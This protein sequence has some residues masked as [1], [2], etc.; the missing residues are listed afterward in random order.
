MPT[1]K[2]IMFYFFFLTVVAL[3]L[4]SFASHHKSSLTLFVW[5]TNVISCLSIK[6]SVFELGMLVTERRR[7]QRGGLGRI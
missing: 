2:L 5:C 4:F 7:A 1:I 6:T 3:L